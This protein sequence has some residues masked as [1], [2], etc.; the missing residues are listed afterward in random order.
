MVVDYD[1][2][3][4]FGLL[5]I[6]V[7]E[8]IG[9]LVFGLLSGLVALV[10]VKRISQDGVLVVT[11]MITFCYA[12][13]LCAEF[14]EVK[15]SGITSVVTFGIFMSAF[16]KQRLIGEAA[17]YMHSFWSYAVFIA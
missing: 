12:I 3:S 17:Q 13:Y 16:G 7:Q 4:I 2:Y 9:G 6:F 10:V 1:H 15:V 11:M 14:S 8:T 5:E